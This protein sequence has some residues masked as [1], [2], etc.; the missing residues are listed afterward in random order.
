[1]TRVETAVEIA[2]AAGERLL[3]HRRRLDRLAVDRKGAIDLVTEADLESERLIRRRLAESF[4]GDGILGEE[5]GRDERG[6]DAPWQWRIDPLDGT[7]NFVH[8]HPFFTVSIGLFR[9]GRPYGGVVYA[10]VLDE[11]FR[12]EEGRGAR[13]NDGPIRVSGVSALDAALLATGFPYRRAELP[14]NNVA[15]FAH[16]V[17]RVRGIRRGGSAA[18]DLAYVACGRFDGYW[19]LHLS[20]WDVAA[21]AALVREAGGR[22]TDFDGGEAWDDGSRIIASNGHLHDAIRHELHTVSLG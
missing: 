16:F 18:L 2:R 1:M 17:V 3:D 20:P 12:A 7:T 6:R 22:V 10:P 14:D 8:G 4:P 13:L 15:N 9:D 11:L 5:L 21:G 19:E